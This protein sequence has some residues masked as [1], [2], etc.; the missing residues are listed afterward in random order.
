MRATGFGINDF[1]LWPDLSRTMLLGLMFIGACTGSTGGGL[2][3]MRIVVIF[4]AARRRIR[5][6]LHPGE[7]QVLRM[8]DNT[9]SEET[10]D[11]ISG[12]LLVFVVVTAAVVLALS[13]DGQDFV[14]TFSAV[15]ACINNIG[16]GLSRVG[17]AGN[18]AFFS[19]WAKLLLSWTMLVGRLELYPMLALLSR[20]TWKK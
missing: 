15:A 10:V 12:Y 18:Y 13:L 8:D 6:T 2:K 4:K 3:V 14:T 16:P 17:P 1:G 9:L 7:V 19:P 20:H 11:S 5:R